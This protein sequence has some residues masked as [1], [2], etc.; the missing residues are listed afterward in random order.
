M[1]K[2]FYVPNQPWLID[3]VRT[4]EDGTPV[5]ALN[6]FTLEQIQAKYPG[7]ILTSLEAATASIETMC[8][9]VPRPIS[10]LDFY[11]AK[12]VLTNYDGYRDS[13]SET[14]KMK[15]HTNGRVTRIY[16]RSGRG[17]WKFEDDCGMTHDN[18]II[19]VAHVQNCQ[20]DLA[21]V[22]A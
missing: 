4:R 17:F 15:E 13:D 21:G 16:A 8:K 20:D 1:K 12:T 10:A 14:F 3:D 6:G 22:V 7:A 2:A 9:T 11:Y 5:S 19:R 18:I